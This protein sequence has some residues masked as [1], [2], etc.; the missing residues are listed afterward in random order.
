M[1]ELSERIW[2]H[3]FAAEL[4]KLFASQGLNGSAALEDAYAHADDHYPRRTFGWP[5]K[6]AE[7]VYRL[8]ITN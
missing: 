5:E 3:R 8:L 7:A 2:K 4:A 1:A 6:E